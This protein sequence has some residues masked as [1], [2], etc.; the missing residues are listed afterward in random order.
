MVFRTL[1]TQGLSFIEKA[2]AASQKTHITETAPR[3]FAGFAVIR[4]NHR[5]APSFV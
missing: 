5:Q 1:Q 2:G 4:T 3:T